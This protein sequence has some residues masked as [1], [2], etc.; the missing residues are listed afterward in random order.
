MSTKLVAKNSKMIAKIK[1]VIYIN[2]QLTNQ[3]LL[4]V[5][6]IPIPISKRKKAAPSKESAAIV[7]TIIKSKLIQQ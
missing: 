2:C 3:Q 4:S 1:V 5:F 6:N 7:I